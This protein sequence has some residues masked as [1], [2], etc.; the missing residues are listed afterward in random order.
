MKSYWW[1]LN[2]SNNKGYDAEFYYALSTTKT[3]FRPSCPSRTPT[4]KTCRSFPQWQRS[5]LKSELI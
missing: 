4:P 3:I 1:Q 2:S 5:F